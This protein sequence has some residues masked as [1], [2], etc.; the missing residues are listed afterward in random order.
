MVVAG[1]GGGGGVMGQG[2]SSALVSTLAIDNCMPIVYG[3]L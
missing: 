2:G 3:N 1:G